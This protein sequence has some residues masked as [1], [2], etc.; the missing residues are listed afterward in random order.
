MTLLRSLWQ[1]R[2]MIR[3]LTASQLQQRYRG[4]LLGVMWT[5]VQPLLMLGIY[6][7]VFGAIFRPRWME[8]NGEASF[9]LVLFC[10]LTAYGFFSDSL[11]RSSSLITGNPNYVKKII[12]P[13]EVLGVTTVLA[14]FV[15]SLAGFGILLVAKWWLSGFVPWT[16]LLFPLAFLPFFLITLSLCWFF[17]S[18][19]VYF[20]DMENL[21][22]LLLSGLMFLSPVFYSLKAVPEKVRPIFFLNPVTW[23]VEDLR[24]VLLWGE[25]P[26]WWIWGGQLCFAGLMLGL[27][28]RWF[29]K[30]QPGFADVL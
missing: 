13:L 18:L 5:L 28:Y 4:S 14:A 25:S 8:A 27:A 3:H 19:S 12:F 9:T 11:S 30:L 6:S 16:A 2:H 21:M 15:Q 24:R 1:Y 7:F 20:R 26:D 22:G 17:A 10:G 29:K 23:A